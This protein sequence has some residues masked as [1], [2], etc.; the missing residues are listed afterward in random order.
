VRLTQKPESQYAQRQPAKK[1]NE[2]PNPTL[3]GLPVFGS[4][5]LWTSAGG[6]GGGRGR[7]LPGRF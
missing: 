4:H 3:E 7:H 2:N 6:G 1:H 5:H